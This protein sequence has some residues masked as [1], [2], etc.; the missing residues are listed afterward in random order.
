M[1]QYILRIMLI[2]VI[3]GMCVATNAQ[4]LFTESFTVILDTTRI[5][6]GTFLPGFKYQNLREE[7]I[8]IE[9]KADMSVRLKKNGLTLANKI[10][11]SRFG[12]QTILSGGYVYGEYRRIY[13]QPITLETFGMVH[14]LDPRGM[15]RKYA[16]GI[17]AR[18]RMIR[19]QK[20]G[21]FGG[22]GPF[23]EYER[24]N[25]NGISDT[26]LIPPD[27]STRE[28]ENI[29]FGTYLSL[30]F[31]PFDAIFLDASL[32]HQSRF[33]E[34][35]TRPRIATSSRIRYN[36]TQYLGLA[37]TYQNIYDPNPLVPI[38]KLFHKVD[39]GISITF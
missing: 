28:M 37:L 20:I 25:F 23:Y 6:K 31:A 17:N 12:G 33:D 5:I 16:L 19:K 29:K 7:L 36:F 8:E 4:I 9:N 24:W 10:S 1:K 21:L 13:D 39:L 32:Y 38:D 2:S 22:V 15:E 35:F 34:V 3:T 14:W 27:E 11:I 30:K 18:W 26:G